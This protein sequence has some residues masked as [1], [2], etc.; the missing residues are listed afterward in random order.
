MPLRRV[1]DTLFKPPPLNSNSSNLLLGMMDNPNSSLLEWR[2]LEEL[3]ELRDTVKDKGTPLQEF[4][5]DNFN[6]LPNFSNPVNPLIPSI[7]CQTNSLK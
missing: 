5:A 4:K 3:E 2:M 1:K 7:K 6:N